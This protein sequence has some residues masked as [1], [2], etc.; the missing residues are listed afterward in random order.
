MTDISETTG[1]FRKLDSQQGVGT[2]HCVGTLIQTQLDFPVPVSGGTECQIQFSTTGGDISFSM[3]FSSDV[4]SGVLETV[5]EPTRVPSDVETISRAFVAP[6][7]GTLL[8]IFDNSYSWFAIKYLSYH[9]EVM[10]PSEEFRCSRIHQLLD[11]TVSEIQIAERNL[12]HAKDQMQS[13][14][15][16][17]ASIEERASLLR[18]TLRDKKARLEKAYDESDEMAARIDASQDKTIGLCIRCLNKALLKKVFGYLS[19]GTT[20]VV[21]K[22]WKLVEDEIKTRN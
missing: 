14:R 6:E 7:D 15:T 9:I 20:R 11:M 17:I 13:L 4:S 8:I 2:Y 12:L 10:S 22:Y 19:P 1:F 18:N 21:C 5:S 3:H 16:E